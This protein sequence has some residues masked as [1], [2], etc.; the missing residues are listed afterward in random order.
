MLVML[1]PT[2]IRV[3]PVLLF[4]VHFLLIC[5]SCV[6]LRYNT[7]DRTSIFRARRAAE[8]GDGVPSL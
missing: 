6:C 2:R 3:S 1:T 8:E 4:L 7:D 5:L